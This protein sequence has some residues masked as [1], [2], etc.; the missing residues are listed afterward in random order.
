ME[1]NLRHCKAC[2]DRLSIENK[3]HIYI[4]CTVY[5]EMRRS[6]ISNLIIPEN[7]LE[8]QAAENFK[9]IFNKPENVKVTAQHILDAFNKRSKIVKRH[10]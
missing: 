8:L 4:Q 3:Y 1:E 9:I 10:I 2:N 6:W 7:F 5:D